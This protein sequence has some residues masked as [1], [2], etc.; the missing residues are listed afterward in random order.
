MGERHGDARSAVLRL[1]SRTASANGSCGLEER[2][3]RC[4]SALEVL[5]ESTIT[6]EP[7]AEALDHPTTRQYG[8]TARFV[9]NRTLSRTGQE[10]GMNIA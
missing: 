5:G 10:R 1:Q 2:C 6:A 3:G 8:V 9:K 4:E 7:G